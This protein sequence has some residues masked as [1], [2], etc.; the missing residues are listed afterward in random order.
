MEQLVGSAPSLTDEAID[1][2]TELTL[3]QKGSISNTAND[4]NEERI[5]KLWEAVRN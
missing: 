1:K 5:H 2:Y 3:L 4:L